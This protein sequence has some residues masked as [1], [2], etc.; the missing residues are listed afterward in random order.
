MTEHYYSTIVNK[1]P[2]HIYAD[3]FKP[4][5]PIIDQSTGQAMRHPVDDRP[6][7]RPWEPSD[8][9]L[10]TMTIHKWATPKP[11]YDEL[12]SEDKH[13]VNT[14]KQ[15]MN[16]TKTAASMHDGKT[17]PHCNF[18]E[19]HI[20]LMTKSDYK[21]HQT[22][23]YRKLGK[24]LQANQIELKSEQIKS[25]MN[26][27]AY[28]LRPPRQYLGCN[29]PEIA[30]YIP[31]TIDSKTVKPAKR[32]TLYQQIEKCISLMN[33][34]QRETKEDLFKATHNTEDQDTLVTLTRDRNWTRIYTT[35]R[36]EY[37][38]N[39]LIADQ[40]YYDWFMQYKPI[41]TTDLMTPRQTKKYFNEWCTE[42]NIQAEKLLNDMHAILKMTHQKV[43]TLYLQGASN[44]GK[45]FLLKGIVPIDSKAGYHTTSKDF[46]F[47]EAVNAP[48]I[49]ITAHSAGLI[50]NSFRKPST[51]SI[52]HTP[53]RRYSTIIHLTKTTPIQMNGQA[54]KN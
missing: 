38:I 6:M 31:R 34:Y 54:T 29:T 2:A 25:P 44:A 46:P 49:M 28:L 52:R 40:K 3:H 41:D 16:G 45:T 1:L 42:Q 17:D 48:L 14:I 53:R 15:Y 7:A 18:H 24:S 12:S 23:P 51:S 27:A 8:G 30:Q 5:V 50:L 37:S 4:Y 35:A 20:H 11:L 32:P 39:N 26:F 9:Q 33:K 21:V 22:Y 19:N 13:I 43:N 10:N 47:G 36:E